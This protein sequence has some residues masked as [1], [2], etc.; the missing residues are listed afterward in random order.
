MKRIATI[1]L[2]GLVAA[3]LSGCAERHS[4]RYY[5]HHPQVRMSELKWC[6][7]QERGAGPTGTA[8]KNCEAAGTAQAYHADSAPPMP[9]N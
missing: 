6:V 1:I 4:V 3:A 7:R 9:V 5:A 8:L 2:A